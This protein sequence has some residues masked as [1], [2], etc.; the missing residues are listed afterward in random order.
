MQT[1]HIAINPKTGGRE[2][3]ASILEAAEF[4]GY[5]AQRPPSFKLPRYVSTGALIDIDSGHGVNYEQGTAS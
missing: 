3:I 1:Y 5:N 2:R 4:E